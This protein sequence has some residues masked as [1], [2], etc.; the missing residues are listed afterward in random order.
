MLLALLGRG[1]GELNNL[2]HFKANFFFDD[3]EQSDVCRAHISYFGNQRPAH[4]PGAGVQLANTAGNQVDQNVGIT[5]LL[6]CFFRKFCV[7]SFFR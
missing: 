7:Q 2:R 4:R 5:N 1:P 3:F 6:Q